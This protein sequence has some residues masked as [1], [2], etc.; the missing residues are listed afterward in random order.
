MVK[1]I[2]KNGDNIY[3]KKSINLASR[4]DI[5]PA[6]PHPAHRHLCAYRGAEHLPRK[7]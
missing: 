6:P 1:K 7:L 2:E 3:L 5:G 4:C